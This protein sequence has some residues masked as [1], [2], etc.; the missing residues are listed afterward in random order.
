MKLNDYL[1]GILEEKK[2][3]GLLRSLRRVET[4]Q[5]THIV[6]EGRKLVNFSSNNYL[7]LCNDPR[8]KQAAIE[9]LKK[10]GTST[11]SSRLISG[12][13][14]LHQKLEEKIAE[15]KKTKSAL[16]FNSG[17]SANLGII[18]SLAQSEAIIFSD[19]LNH[20]S[21]VDAIILS[22]AKFL[23]YNHNDTEHLESLL[24][25]YS[26][27]EQ[28]FIIT[29]T[30]FSM[31]GD[32]AEL[33][34]IVKLAKDYNAYIFVDEAHAT[35]VFGPG[36]SGLVE[37]FGLCE[38]IDIQMG[39]LSK[40]LGS[41][42]AFV[43]GSKALTDY[44]V[45]TS[46]AFIYTTSLPPAVLAASIK[47]IEIIKEE[48]QRRSKLWENIEFMRGNIVGM[49]LDCLNS[50]SAIIPIMLGDNNLTMEFSKRLFESGIFIQGIRPPTVGQGKARLR[51]T[52]TATH[53][54]D[55]L[56][57]ALDAIKINAKE[58]GLIN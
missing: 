9:A 12:T 26:D 11:A 32:K 57:R 40:A 52:L 38:E 13:F 46:R 7:G 8:L 25:K 53:T 30:I 29:D 21:I 39:T 31:D 15:F 35:G 27:T 49:G 14:S 58:L 5:D 54:K 48:P 44:L 19:R 45:N 28:K 41:F 1:T 43:C 20:A 42:G 47:A 10:F 2:E 18:S 56:S 55:D 4:P 36:G 3:Q 16:V 50:S 51:I 37:E 34:K 22:Q 33:K 17:Y 6:I 23:R 24:D